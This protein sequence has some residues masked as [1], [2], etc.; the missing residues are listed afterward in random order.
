MTGHLLLG[1]RRGVAEL[2]EVDAKALVELVQPLDRAV[3]IDWILVPAFAQ[4]GDD[5]L[6]LAERVGADEDAAARVRVQP[7][8]QPVD[9]APCFNVSIE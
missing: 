5:P 7:V 6:R 3:E 1:R 9:L 2:A 8:E 4:L